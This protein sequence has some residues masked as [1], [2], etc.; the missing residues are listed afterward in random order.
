MIT[1]K[2]NMTKLRTK[3]EIAEY[4]GI[5]IKTV[6]VLQDSGLLKSREI[7]CN[8]NRPDKI[9]IHKRSTLQDCEDYL[10]NSNGRR[11]R[12]S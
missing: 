8:P 4:L 10:H 9:R 11:K 7:S 6:T 3:K 12:I 5:C 1:D 2:D